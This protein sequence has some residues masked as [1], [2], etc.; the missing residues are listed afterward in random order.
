MFAKEANKWNLRII[1]E[2]SSFH[3]D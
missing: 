1:W 2:L 3:K